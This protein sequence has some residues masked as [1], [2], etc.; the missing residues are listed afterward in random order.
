MSKYNRHQAVI[1]R[2]SDSPSGEVSWLG[3]LQ[4]NLLEKSAVQPRSVDQS[5]FHQ[6]NSIM[7]GK[8]KYPS[9]E[10]AVEDMKA[11]SGLTAYLEKINKTSEEETIGEHK[12]IASDQNELRH[13][14]EVIKR[15]PQVKTTLENYIKDTRGNLPLSAILEK[16]KTIHKND[17]SEDKHWEDE[18]L[19]RLVSQMNLREKQ[20][21]PSSY[22]TYSNLG[23]R[24][25]AGDDAIDPSNTDA[26]SALNPVKI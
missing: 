14:P 10:A 17:V 22:E 11:R 8:S 21:N 15:C 7:N 25:P 26:F 12:K 20:N 1:S 23:R 6:I 9:V 4:K 24:D 2:N 16:I 18:K 3:E 19:I 13:L 5:L